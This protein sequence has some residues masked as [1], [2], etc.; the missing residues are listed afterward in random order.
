MNNEDKFD[1]KIAGYKGSKT[2][3]LFCNNNGS[4]NIVESNLKNIFDL[5][6]FGHFNIEN[7]EIFQ[8]DIKE[9]IIPKMNKIV[10]LIIYDNPDLESINFENL[11]SSLIKEILIEENP[12][13]KIDLSEFSK[14]IN[15]TDLNL[16][17]SNCSGS[18][19]YLR[20]L[21]K[22]ENLSIYETNIIPSFEYLKDEIEFC[23]NGII[24]ENSKTIDKFLTLQRKL[25]ISE[26]KIKHPELVNNANKI[27]EYYEYLTPFYRFI[28]TLDFLKKFK[29]ELIFINNENSKEEN[30]KYF[31]STKAARFDILFQII[32][33]FFYDENKYLN[34][35]IQFSTEDYYQK[36]INNP[37]E[38]QTTTLLEQTSI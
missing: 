8:S 37:K 6:E 2:F 36:L 13:L 29:G 11:N 38:I 25:S 19:F 35:K 34:K 30:N 3:S 22:L 27:I 7:I 5:Q 4:L 23:S 26:F 32:S 18:L 17:N 16:S 1:I 14:F 31:Y 20:N 21:T 9:I 28:K 24:H 12:K 15:L 33:K 10:S